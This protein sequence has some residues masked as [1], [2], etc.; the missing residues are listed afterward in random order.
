VHGPS[1]SDLV[2]LGLSI[3]LASEFA[4][5]RLRCPLSSAVRRAPS[6]SVRW[7]GIVVPLR[8]GD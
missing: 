8:T 6:G 2:S 1:E 5:N 3:D 7:C 4:P